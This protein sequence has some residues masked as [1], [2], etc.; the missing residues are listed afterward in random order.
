MKL[1]LVLLLLL[2]CIFCNAQTTSPLIDSL[3]KL[4]PVQKNS[5]PVQTYNELTW[6]YR[7]VDREK[8]ISY[9][10]KAIET[11]RQ[12]NYL[13]GVA[14]AYN[15][16]GI[17]FYDKENYDTAIQ[18]YQQAMQIRQQLNDNLG[19]AKLYNKIGVIYQKQG[20]FAKAEENQLKALELFRKSENDIGIS[21]S[22]NN[23]GILNQ[24]MGRYDEAIK[25][26][27][28]SIV[29]KEK[30]NDKIGLAGSYVNVGNIYLIVE[31]FDSA[32]LFYLKATDISRQLKDKEYLSNTLN[33]LGKL[34]I[35]TKAFD[36]ALP[37]IRESYDLRT[38]LG[39]TKGTVSCLNNLSEIFIGL[40]RY[41]SAEITLTKGMALA[42]TAVNCK[43]ELNSIYQNFSAL[44][45]AKGN[46]GKAL[47]MY[48]LYSQT[49]DSL[50]TDEL[51]Q[52]FADLETKYKTLEKE[53]QIQQQQ[54]QI[55]QRNYWIAGICGLVLLGSLLTYSYYRRYKL[56]Q[57]SRLQAE[58]L[59]QQ[60]LAT[61]AVIEAEEKERKRIA[62]DLHDGVGQL[63]SAARMNLS[64][65]QS[66]LPFISVEQKN[67]FE[68]VVS[69]IDDSC[70]EVRSVSHNMMPNA[71]LKAGL[72]AA[73]REFIDKIDAHIIK[74]NL[75]AEGLNER[76][77]SNVETV[78]Y[79]VIQECVNNVIK[80][81]KASQLDI[82]LIKDTEGISATIEDNGKGFDAKDLNKF[83]G[84]GLKNIHSRIDYLRGSVEWDSTPGNGT[85][86]AIHVPVK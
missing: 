28:Q 56:K 81:A 39:D 37:V 16:L 42:K 70:N 6:Q 41:D 61:K 80:H 60:E 30:I 74:V 29:I 69:L 47:E 34:Y 13:K 3:E 4:V 50:Y 43:P 36:K 1:F 19:I 67:N 58:I 44:Y 78:L 75:H 12:I 23:I 27:L 17:I 33:N 20:A 35:K 77:D 49:K 48:K 9:G 86:V 14:Q 83:N 32:K 59:K 73:I 22:L 18:L 55:Q 24:N 31:K 84:I 65:I 85:L 26:Q 8:A 66:N 57:Q 79:R 10:N 64:A 51:G 25:Y 63:M 62:G 2:P 45:E 68:K 71:L 53:N 52:T 40:K 72:A 7:L 11:G 46:I 5:T 54:F 76:I 82:S 21:Y 38:A 15:D